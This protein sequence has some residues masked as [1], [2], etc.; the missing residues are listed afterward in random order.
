MI[1]ETRLAD[2]RILEGKVYTRNDDILE[3]AAL[4]LTSVVEQS[5]PNRGILSEARIKFSI[6]LTNREVTTLRLIK[7]LQIETLCYGRT[8]T[9]IGIY[10]YKELGEYY[11]CLNNVNDLLPKYYDET[12]YLQGAPTPP[13]RMPT[14]K[15]IRKE[16]EPG[17]FPN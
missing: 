9:I 15:Q 6:P 8:Y 13:S 4:D 10:A 12:A 1:I 14:S 17:F 11:V 2:L 16:I 7:H 5:N 3:P